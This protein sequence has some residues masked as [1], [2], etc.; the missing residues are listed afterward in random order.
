[1]FYADREAVEEFGRR[2][3]EEAAGGGQ[4]QVF[5]DVYGIDASSLS[6]LW[7]QLVDAGLIRGEGAE[8]SQFGFVQEGED[9]IPVLRGDGEEVR[10][11]RVDVDTIAR[12][13]HEGDEPRPLEFQVAELADILI[14]H[15]NL[16]LAERRGTPGQ[17][18]PEPVD[19][20]AA[21]KA[22]TLQREQDASGD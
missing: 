6:R 14:G 2:T 15:A 10:G 7:K 20:P 9:A 17:E 5:A 3:A 19:D 13:G 1:M 18:A 12:G 16:L 4:A 21:P 8:P 22:P 11:E